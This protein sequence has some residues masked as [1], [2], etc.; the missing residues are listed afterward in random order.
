MNKIKNYIPLIK[1]LKQLGY[2]VFVIFVEVPPSV[3]KERVLKRYQHTGRYVPRIVVDEANKAGL[4]AF[5][6]IREMASGWMLV[7]G[8]TAEITKVEGEKIPDDRDYFKKP[9][10]AKDKK[11]KIAKA[12]A[13]AR[14][15]RLRLL[16]I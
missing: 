5:K 8:E 2:K 14:S 15:R 6:V 13:S 9:F 12:K 4:D 7:D 10:T 11:I 1:K 16:N 3:S